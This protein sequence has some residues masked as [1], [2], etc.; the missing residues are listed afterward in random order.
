[1]RITKDRMVNVLGPAP[2][3]EIVWQEQFDRNDEVLR[4][5]ARLDWDQIG[6]TGHLGSYH[7]DLAFVDLQPDLFRHV[8]PACL[9]LWYETLS[10]DEA[11]T[12]SFHVGLMYG[13][14]IETM[15]SESERRSLYNF[16]ADGFMDRIEAERGF[17]YHQSKTIMI[18]SGKSA[19][20]WI[21]RFNTLGIIAPVIRQIWEDWWA[22]DHPGKGCLGGDV[23]VRFSVLE[24]RKP[25]LRSLYRGTWRGRPVSNSE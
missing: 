20:A 11:N 7:E 12:S 3:P 6:A 10:R 1:M 16:F 19:N 5:M 24:G 21:Y 15:L 25:N 13:Q 9:K 17:V 4:E 2:K 23:C 14:I 22:L 8:F 18:S